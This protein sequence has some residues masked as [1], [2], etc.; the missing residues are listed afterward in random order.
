MEQLRAARRI[1]LAEG[2]GGV[3]HN[4]SFADGGPVLQFK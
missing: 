3:A 1:D 4:V 2:G